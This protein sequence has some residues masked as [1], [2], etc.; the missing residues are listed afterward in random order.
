MRAVDTALVFLSCGPCRSWTAP[1]SASTAA[2]CSPS[3]V[4]CLHKSLCSCRRNCMWSLHVMTYF[5]SSITM[6]T[7]I[8][9]VL[10]HFFTASS[11]DMLTSSITMATLG[12]RGHSEGAWMDTHCTMLLV[13]KVVWMLLVSKVVWMLLVSKVVWMVQQLEWCVHV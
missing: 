7:L 4:V 10:H 8:S 13:S 12:R 1:W 9:H 6:A 3:R 2:C 11:K 5:A